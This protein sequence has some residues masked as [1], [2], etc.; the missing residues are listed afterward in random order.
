[1]F[2][3]WQ[4]YYIGLS[5]I[6]KLRLHDSKSGMTLGVFVYFLGGGLSVIF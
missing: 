3:Q 1:M 5:Y 6:L 2:T 4:K